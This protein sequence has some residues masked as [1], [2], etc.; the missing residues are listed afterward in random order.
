MVQLDIRVDAAPGEAVKAMEMP[1]AFT[2]VGQGGANVL[3]DQIVNA[4]WVVDA[5]GVQLRGG[6]VYA[7][8]YGGCCELPRYWSSVEAA[9]D[10]HG[11]LILDADGTVRA[12][13]DEAPREAA[14]GDEAAPCD[15]VPGGDNS[16][17]G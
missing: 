3:G 14:P 10:F 16:E 8:C 6:A 17:A 9:A 4:A 11:S 5:E 2:L 1:R 12:P 13:R 7:W 15:V